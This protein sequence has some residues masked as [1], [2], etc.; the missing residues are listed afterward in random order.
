MAEQI[1]LINVR[2]V[3]AR[4]P[5]LLL[6]VAA[7]VAAWYAVRWGVGDTMAEYAPVSYAKDPAAAFETAES[8]A[9]LAP[10]DPL[11]HLMLARLY[12]YTFDPKD[13]PR[14]RAEYERAAA[15]APNSYLVWTEVGRAR[16]QFGD[17][18]GGV[19][20]LKRAVE[21]APNYSEPRWHLGN[22]LLRAGQTDEA[23]AELRR[24]AD[25]EPTL[26]PQVFNLAWQVYAQDMPRVIDAIG[27]SPAARAQLIGVLVGR[28]R[29]DEAIGVWSSL[30][31][32]EMR[33]QAAAGEGLARALH[34]RGLYRR[35]LQ[36]L[37]EAGVQG[38]ALEKISNGSFESDIGQ[39]GKQLFQWQVTTPALAQVAVDARAARE[40]RRSLRI[41]FNASGQA[42]FRNVWQ[43]VAIEPATRYRLSYFFRTEELKSAATLVTLVTDAGGEGNVFGTSA[44]VQSGT[45]EWQQVTIEFDTGAKTEA[46]VVRLV[47]V[48]CPG[49]G[50]PIYGKIWYDDFDL[51]RTGGRVAPR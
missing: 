49:E 5:L 43:V 45:N 50:C 33:A 17:A 16:G 41:L 20:A 35:A 15:L 10:D 9:R 7:L 29:F 34:D 47:R 39:T 25:A 32:E 31:A 30:S 46:V 42:D 14:A 4:L 2:P 37:G 48:A 12:R 24:A 27:K 13:L 26:R 8:A 44:P 6:A 21:L 3:W 28:G 1:A 36:T 40:G 23:F 22:A 18:A 38:L 19:A 11:T 51:Q